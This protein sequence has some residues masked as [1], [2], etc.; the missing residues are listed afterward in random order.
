MI[1]IREAHS[2]DAVYFGDRGH[3]LVA[4]AVHRNSGALDR[5]NFQALERKLQG[6]SEWAIERSS[7]WLVGWVDFL[8]VE[9][10]SEAEAVAEEALEA[11][12]NYPVLDDEL[13][14]ELLAEDVEATW[15]MLPM[16]ARIRLLAEHG[17][18]IFAARAETASELCKRAP[19]TY[20]A[21][22]EN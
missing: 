3:W 4:L 1:T 17:E 18:S 15:Q 13:Y 21:L 11:L 12:R 16:R 14:D 2:E 22:Q 20:Y 10:G 6:I 5:A 19:E 8:I 9:P 7:D